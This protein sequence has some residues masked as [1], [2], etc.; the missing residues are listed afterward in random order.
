M[1]AILG[2]IHFSAAKSYFIKAADDVIK[3]FTS[4][5]YNNKDNELI[6]AGDLVAFAINGGLVLELLFRLFMASRFKHIHVVVGNHDKKMKDG[7]QQLA[8]SFL[9][10]M[11]N[12]TV[13]EKPSIVNIQDM[14]VLLLPYYRVTGFQK[15]M[16]EVYSNLYQESKYKRHFDLVVGHFS[17]TSITF[18]SSDTVSNMDKLDADTICL[19]H[20]HQRIN[21]DIY[22]GSIYANR[23]NENANDRAAWLISKE[24]KTEDP[25][26]NFIEFVTAKYPDELPTSNALTPVY[27]ITNCSGEK[28]ARELYGNIFIKA[29]LKNISGTSTFEDDLNSTDILD[30]KIPEIFKEFL[31]KQDPPLDRRVAKT[32]LSLLENPTNSIDGND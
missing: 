32:C 11:P 22:I 16:Q 23:V 6:L 29:T 18:V 12:V 30:V 10:H 20:I 14:D 7:I 3:W 19:G 8:Y 26:P 5:K 27:T 15:S 13:Y 2:D 24:G 1:I 17:E 9:Y 21:P 4:W 28:V 25:L 31:Q